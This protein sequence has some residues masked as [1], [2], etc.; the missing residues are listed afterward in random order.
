MNSV[1]TEWPEDDHVNE[2]L[3]A[4]GAFVE[5]DT[6]GQVRRIRLSG[7]VYDDSSIDLLSTIDGLE[8]LDVQDTQITKAGV[9]RLR[10]LLPDTDVLGP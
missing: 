2:R 7:S 6:V 5:Y 9:R 3:R 10:K 1:A 4:R 8:V